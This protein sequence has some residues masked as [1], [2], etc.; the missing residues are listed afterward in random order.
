MRVFQ[1]W[2]IR[3]KQAN[4]QI[5]TPEMVVTVTTKYHCTTPFSNGISEVAETYMKI[6]HCDIKKLGC[7][8][9]DFKFKALG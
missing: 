5:L 6:Y 3:G 1:V 4:G 2:P 9:G 8:S 7:C